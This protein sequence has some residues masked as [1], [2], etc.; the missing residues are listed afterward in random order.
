MK[1][2]LRLGGTGVLGLEASVHN[3]L[4]GVPGVSKASVSGSQVEVRTSNV[5]LCAQL[6]TGPLTLTQQLSHIA[7][8]LPFGVC[9]V[10]YDP[11]QL[12]DPNSLV[13]ALESTGVAVAELQSAEP[14]PPASQLARL[15]VGGMTC[16]SCSSC[17]ESALAALPGVRHAS[18]SLT[19]Q[20][21]KV[22]FDPGL[23]TEVWFSSVGAGPGLTWG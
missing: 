2:V 19:L 13:D 11:Q 10:A 12:A 21:A 3:V 16:S 20:E 4:A 18:V 7:L 15:R 5:A 6:G 23:V 1:A 9:Q 14:L 8:L 22:E 17:V